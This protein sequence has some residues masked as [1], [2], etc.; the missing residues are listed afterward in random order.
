MRRMSL[1]GARSHSE[2][3]T[4]GGGCRESQRAHDRAARIGQ[5]DAGEAIRGPSAAA[6][7]EE[8]MEITIATR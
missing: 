7:F 2:T 5:D 4:A 8:A 1:S 3:G 6:Q